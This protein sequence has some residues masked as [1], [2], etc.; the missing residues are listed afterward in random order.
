M[1]YSKIGSLTLIYSTSISI[2]HIILTPFQTVVI[3]LLRFILEI[4]SSYN[5]HNN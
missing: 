5:Q 4:N 2:F 1:D 3:K